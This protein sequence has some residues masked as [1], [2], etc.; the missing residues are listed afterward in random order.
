[1]HGWGQ[2]RTWVQVHPALDSESGQALAVGLTT[3]AVDDGAVVEELL[4]QVDTKI[5]SFSGD[6]AYDKDKVRKALHQRALE[7]G[8]DILQIIPPQHNAV[9]DEKHRAYLCQ[10]DD[11]ITQIESLGRAEWK[12]VTGYHQRSKAETFMFRYKVILG[13]SLQAR[14]FNQQES[15]V[16]TGCKILNIMLHLAKP[17]SERVA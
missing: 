1:M 12:V 6:G 10:R 9:R 8:E 7:Q 15:E 16:K 13:G 3:N 11:D 17:Q 2:R 4:K 14:K 5:N